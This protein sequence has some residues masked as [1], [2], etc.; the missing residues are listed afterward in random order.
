MGYYEIKFRAGWIVVAIIFFIIFGVLYSNGSFKNNKVKIVFGLVT[1]VVVAVAFKSIFF[2][3]Q[4]VRYDL[5]EK[6]IEKII[7][8][9]ENIDA[10]ITDENQIEKIVSYFNNMSDIKRN[11]EQGGPGTPEKVISIYLDNGGKITLSTLGI[12]GWCVDLY[13]LGRSPET[14]SYTGDSKEL[15]Q[16]FEK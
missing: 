2:Y 8:H 9:G 6:D 10:E 12:D 5:D 16:L 14:S 1:V 4:N 15:A 13:N 7:L 11:P 3:H